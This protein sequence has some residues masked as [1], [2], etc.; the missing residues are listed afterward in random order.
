M[1]AVMS[2]SGLGKSLVAAWQLQLSMPG[3]RM[4]TQL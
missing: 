3:L 1:P 2:A 4:E